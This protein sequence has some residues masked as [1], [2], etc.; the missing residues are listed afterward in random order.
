[1]KKERLK[2]KRVIA[3][4]LGVVMLCGMVGCGNTETAKKKETYDTFVAGFG[5][6][7][8][9]PEYEVHMASHGDEASRVSQGI[10]TDLYALVVAMSDTEGNTMLWITTDV[11]QG[12]IVMADLVRKEVE[13]KYGIPKENVLL[14]GTHNHS[15]V[16]WSFEADANK[17]FQEDWLAGVMKSIDAA[18]EDRAPATME[19]G[20]TESEGLAFVRRY[21]RADG[22]LL[23]G[24]DLVMVFIAWISRN[25]TSMVL[26]LCN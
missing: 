7:I 26:P 14:S 8:I 11:T 17:R 15:S 1:M 4:A 19:I 13:E 18:L 16:S 6:T 25:I 23:S 24:G 5:K 12:N 2:M 10:L 20:R 21:W 3:M 9:T 22:T